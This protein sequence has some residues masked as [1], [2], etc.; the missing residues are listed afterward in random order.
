MNTARISVEIINLISLLFYSLPLLH[1]L[2]VK[3]LVLDW[4]KVLMSYYFKVVKINKGKHHLKW[5][6]EA[7]KRELSFMYQLLLAACITSR[8]KKLIISTSA[9]C[10]EFFV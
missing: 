7:P 2:S 6:Q 9:V 4:W 3:I 1:T 5:N 8:K 10:V